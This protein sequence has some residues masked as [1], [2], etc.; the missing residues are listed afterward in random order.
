MTYPID[1]L[2]LIVQAL[3]QTGNNS[4]SVSD[5]GSEE[6]NVGSA[7]YESALEYM[8]DQGDWKQL[9]TVATL[10]PTGVAPTD[11]EFDTAFAKPPDC[12]HVT[13]VRVNYGSVSDDGFFAGSV[14]INYQVLTNQIVVNLFS[15][16][17]GASPPPGTPSPTITMKYVSS[18]PP[19]GLVDQNGNPLPGTGVPAQ[20][21]RTFMTALERFVFAGIYRGLNKNLAEA[22]YHEQLGMKLLQEARSRSDQEQPKR[23]V[24]NSRI[25]ASRRVRRPFPQTPTGWG[26]TGVPG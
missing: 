13:W 17:G 14:P 16:P 1:K 25:T 15:E 9:T 7:A 24:F 10:Q 23:A 8:L 2:G 19:S 18:S 22:K 12:I 21:L 11:D 5:D 26:G 4:P 3:Q 6:W 20:M